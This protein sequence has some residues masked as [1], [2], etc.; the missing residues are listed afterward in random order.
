[1]AIRG[2][3]Q[4]AAL[5]TTIAAMVACGHSGQSAT[6]SELT[7]SPDT[8]DDQ[9]V[10]VSGTVKNPTTRQTRRG[11]ATIYQLCD[12]ACINVIQFGGGSVSDGTASTVTGHFRASFG[13]QRKMTNV[14]IVGGRR[15][16]HG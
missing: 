14:L 6:T 11:T 1:M 10:T 13:R 7:A 2:F 9:D 4:G 3:L 5:T 12:N 15:E 8:Y 16:S